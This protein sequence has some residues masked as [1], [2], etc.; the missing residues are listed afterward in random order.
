MLFADAFTVNF[1]V[2]RS[3][4]KRAINLTRERGQVQS[5]MEVKQTRDEEEG[6]ILRSPEA[7]AL[8]TRAMMYH[9]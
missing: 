6:H 7:H 1:D 4:I 3:A 9:A 2:L 5:K 8:K